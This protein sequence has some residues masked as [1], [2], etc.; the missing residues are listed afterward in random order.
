MSGG[1]KPMH[2]HADE[3]RRKE[4]EARESSDRMAASSVKED[5]RER[6]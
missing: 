2:K 1:G 4:E 5:T 3:K 6:L